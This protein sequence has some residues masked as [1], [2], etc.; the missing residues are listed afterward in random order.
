[1]R[2]NSLPDEVFVKL[3]PGT[4]TL[5]TID[6]AHTIDFSGAANAEAYAVVDGMI[7]Y[8][9]SQL[10][11]LKGTIPVR[12]NSAYFTVPADA[13]QK[14]KKKRG[15]VEEKAWVVNKRCAK[16]QKRRMEELMTESGV[17]AEY[18]AKLTR[19]NTTREMKM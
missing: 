13:A 7:P 15:V 9:A 3:R 11:Y 2:R 4:T 1:M 10:D 5:M 19:L 18:V 17:Y 6:A 8:T 14:K 12:S 16:W